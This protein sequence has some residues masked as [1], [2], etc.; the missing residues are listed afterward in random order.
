MTGDR[1]K[2]SYIKRLKCD[3]SLK[4]MYT[5]LNYPSSSDII[6]ILTDLTE[7]DN[8]DDKREGTITFFG[9]SRA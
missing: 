2:S 1:W 8:D 7:E 4:S 3:N 6:V 9:A 5:V